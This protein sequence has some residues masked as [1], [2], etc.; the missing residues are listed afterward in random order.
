K[1][2]T[3][4]QGNDANPVRIYKRIPANVKCIRAALEGVEDGRDILRAP[5]FERRDLLAQSARCC[6]YLTHLKYTDGIAS[7][8]HDRQTAKTR[9]NFAQQFEPLVGDLGFLERKSGDVPAGPR[10]T[11][12]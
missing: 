2:C 6:L 12:D 7:I 5:D 3:K 1:A 4:R 10:Q 8:S 9:N 11:R